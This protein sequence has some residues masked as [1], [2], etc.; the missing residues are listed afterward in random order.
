MAN[1]ELE[2]L[3]GALGSDVPFF[4]RGGAALVEGRG[5]RITALPPIRKL[6]AIVVVP[7]LFIPA[8][9]AT[10]YGTLRP[11]DFSDGSRIAAEPPSWLEAN[12]A[13]A[14]ERPL[15]DIAPDVQ[16]IPR[17]MRQL[18]A[19][20]IGLSGAGPAHFA[21]DDDRERARRIA[22]TL[23]TEWAGRADIYLR[24]FLRRGVLL[25]EAGDL[26]TACSWR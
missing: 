14:F 8:K 16:A 26:A 17:R 24:S 15:Y 19:R 10:L 7:H 6:V 5:E 13:N 12:L 3:G 20:A 4:F 9:T 18:G 2:L 25:G 22:A 1:Q 23:S 11:T 21:L